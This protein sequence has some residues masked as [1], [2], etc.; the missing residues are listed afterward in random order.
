[1]LQLLLVYLVFAYVTGKGIHV[2]YGGK[3]IHAI[4]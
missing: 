2:K 3:I 1:M 4:H